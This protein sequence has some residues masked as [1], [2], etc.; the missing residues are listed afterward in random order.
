M[1][2]K[3]VS[4]VLLVLPIVLLLMACG[5]R[6]VLIDDLPVYPA[7]VPMELGQNSLAD[8]VTTTMQQ[9]ATEQGLSA[10]FRL[11][12]LPAGVTWDDVDNFYT[13]ELAH[14]DWKPEPAMDVTGDTF[15]AAGWSQGTGDKQ[16][17]LMVG[18]VPD[19]TGEG[20]FA[21]VGLFAR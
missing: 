1:E 18:Y 7:A 16:E 19:V 3:V 15:Q 8:S 20:A 21:F 12:G 14:L 6:P 5:A 13:Q 10:Q 4:R 2:R 17:A 9:S 11:F